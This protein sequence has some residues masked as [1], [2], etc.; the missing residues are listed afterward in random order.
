MIS[1]IFACV[2]LKRSLIAADELGPEVSVL[3]WVLALVGIEGK[4]L[5]GLENVVGL[6]KVVQ[7]GEVKLLRLLSRRVRVV[8]L[9]VCLRWLIV[10]HFHE[11]RHRH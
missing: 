2:C 1:K 11:E 6:L 10:V 9:R 8:P 4:H 5:G 7:V 3:A